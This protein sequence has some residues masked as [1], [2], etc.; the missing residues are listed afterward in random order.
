M[1]QHIIMDIEGT[2]TSIDFVHKILFPYSLKR[3]SDFVEE[4]ISE[5]AVA[6]A[7]QGVLNSPATQSNIGEI[8][9]SLEDWII[10]DKKHTSLKEAHWKW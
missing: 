8:I 10:N 7:L 3:I 6:S 5:P 9:K 1:I 2:T 4:N